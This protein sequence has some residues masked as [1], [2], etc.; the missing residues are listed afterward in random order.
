MRV[1]QDQFF[2]R[3]ANGAR[4]VLPC[5]QF[6]AQLL[7]DDRGPV[8]VTWS[9]TTAFPRWS[10]VVFVDRP[11]VA[12]RSALSP[13]SSQRLADLRF[14]IGRE[15]A[16]RLSHPPILDK[17]ALLYQHECSIYGREGIVQD[18]P[19]WFQQENPA[20]QHHRSRRPAARTQAAR[21]TPQA[22]ESDFLQEVGTLVATWLRHHARWKRRR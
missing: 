3:T 11:E 8:E 7:R 21:R 4:S 12:F 15:L 6:R 1:V 17:D 18:C 2:A 13:T 19:P 9:P 22:Q 14:R 20:G 16:G 5:Q 10:W